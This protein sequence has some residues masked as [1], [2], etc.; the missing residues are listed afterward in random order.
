M[1]HNIIRCLVRK[2]AE[3]SPRGGWGCYRAR[4][5]IFV[6]TQV[7]VVPW[8]TEF[9]SMAKNFDG[10][11]LSNG[12]TY[13][14]WRSFH[15]QTHCRGCSKGRG[16][17]PCVS[18]RLISYSKCCRLR[19]SAADTLRVAS[20]TAKQFAQAGDIRPIFG[21]CLGNQLLGLAAGLLSENALALPW[22]VL[23][24]AP[25][26]QEQILRSCRLGIVGTTNRSTLC[27]CS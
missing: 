3:V 19:S 2:G 13:D 8:D 10:L 26:I 23:T 17:P 22:R 6:I 25:T 20:H 15:Y 16:T 9:S 7:T 24:L 18:K 1:K 12:N 21:I 4:P 14:E 5:K 11:F 27:T